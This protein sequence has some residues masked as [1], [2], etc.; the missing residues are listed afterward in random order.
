M[1][2]NRDAPF[3]YTTFGGNSNSMS[4][5]SAPQV[6]N[7]SDVGAFEVDLGTPNAKGAYKELN[8]GVFINPKAQQSLA[9]IGGEASGWNA[10]ASLKPTDSLKQHREYVC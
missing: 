3:N 2:A 8:S 5:S 7:F 1:M 10:L 9:A 4:R 6:V